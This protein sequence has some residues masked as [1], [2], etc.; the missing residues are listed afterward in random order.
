MVLFFLLL[1]VSVFAQNFEGEIIYNISYKSST[2]Q[3][4]TEQLS[5]M[6]GNMQTYSYKNGNYKSVFNGQVVQWMM[7]AKAENRIYSKMS[8][9]ST[10]YWNDASLNDDTVISAKL[11]EG[12]VEILGY[13]CDEILLECKMGMQKFYFNSKLAVDPALFVNHKLGNWYDFVS[14]SKALPLK[15]EINNGQFEIISVATKVTPKK[16]ENSLFALPTDAKI[17]KSPY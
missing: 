14:R 3:L 17:E 13:K 10:I 4:K 7:Y 11:N 1:S 8:T 5:A 2:P 16:L 12:V 15:M 6:M 9:A